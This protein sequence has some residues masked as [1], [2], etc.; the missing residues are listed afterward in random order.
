M[1]FY[2]SI[3]KPRL[4]FFLLSAFKVLRP[5]LKGIVS[6]DE[7]INSFAK[8]YA[9]L[10]EWNEIP[11]SGYNLLRDSFHQSC[12]VKDYITLLHIKPDVKVSK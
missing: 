4:P 2:I 5:H 7:D 11:T 12:L 3:C 9:P 6:F 10:H 1:Y 8:S